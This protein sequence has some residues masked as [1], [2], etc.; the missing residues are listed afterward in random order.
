[1]L[2]HISSD[3][4]IVQEPE[5]RFNNE[6]QAWCKVRVV[7]K[8]RAYNAETKAWEDKGDPCYLDLLVSGKAAENLYESVKVGD[9]IVVTGRLQQREWTTNEGEK[10]VSYQIRA[11][12]IGVN[13]IYSPLMRKD[14][15]RSTAPAAA[16]AQ[17]DDAPF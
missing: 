11:D 16:A 12:S 14:I 13:V 2:P 17:A 9:S 8:D 4:G 6:G 10:R 15:D 5:L 7:A 3:F 1:M